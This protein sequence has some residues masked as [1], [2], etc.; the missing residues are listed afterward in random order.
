MSSLCKIKRHSQVITL[1]TGDNLSPLVCKSPGKK[2]SKSYKIK[3]GHFKLQTTV[4]IPDPHHLAVTMC[5]TTRWQQTV[6]FGGSQLSEKT[7]STRN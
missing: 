5:L 2:L 1:K 3:K 6:I 7:S 4:A